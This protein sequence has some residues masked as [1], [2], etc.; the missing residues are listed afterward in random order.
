MKIRSGFVSN[1]SSSSFIVAF[2]KKPK[3]E[4]DVLNMMFKGN[5]DEVI[6]P[7]WGDT[8]MTTKAIASQVF[9]DLKDTKPTKKELREDFEGRYYVSNGTLY[10]QG[11][12]Y[13]ASSKELVDKLIQLTNQHENDYK[14]FSQFERE[15]ICKHGLGNYPKYAYKGG[16]DYT[17][18]VPFTDE[19]IKKYND[20]HKALET[21]KKTNKEFLKKSKEYNAKMRK[22]RK[23]SHKVR[24]AL[25]KLDL[26][27][28]LKDVNGSYVASFTYSDNDGT[29]GALMEHSD[30]FRNLKHIQF[31]HH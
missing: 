18:K 27:A 15:L 24:V 5:P 25:A 28:W 22:Y 6:M 20:H 3:T 21:L 11:E 8:G 9:K 12:E 29:Q 26:A 1:S 14:E 31:S 7:S 23:E 19:E 2:P 13:F 16:C 17:T 4:A 30:I 10:W